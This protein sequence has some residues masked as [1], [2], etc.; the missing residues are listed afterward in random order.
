MPRQEEI[1]WGH[2]RETSFTHQLKQLIVTK[3]KVTQ[4]SLTLCNPVDCTLPGSSVDGIF[5]ARNTGVGCHF[6]L[7]GIFPTQGL[8]QGLLHCRQTLYHLSHR[9]S[10]IQQAGGEP[11]R[12][13]DGWGRVRERLEPLFCR[14]SLQCRNH[15]PLVKME[16]EIFKV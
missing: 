16:G 10:P 15:Q 13:D 2:Q 3:E 11:S 5:Q 1:G 6:L 14:S 4:S 9:G 12:E 8:K 7:Q